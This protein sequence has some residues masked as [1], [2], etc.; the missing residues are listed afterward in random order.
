M[1]FHAS[2]VETG[3]R[4]MREM[5]GREGSI[6]CRFTHLYPDGPAQGA[7]RGLRSRSARHPA[8]CA[9]QMSQPA[10]AFTVRSVSRVPLVMDAPRRTWPRS[11]MRDHAATLNEIARELHVTKAAVYRHVRS[12]EELLRGSSPRSAPPS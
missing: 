7:T 10:D 3:R 6:T 11:L 1:D 8:A 2:I 5:T 4:V 12:K 9:T